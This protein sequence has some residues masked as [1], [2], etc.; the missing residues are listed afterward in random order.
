MMMMFRY[1]VVV[2][3]ERG[4]RPNI[5]AQ[6]D[7]LS[8]TVSFLHSAV[9]FL[10]VKLMKIHFICITVSQLLPESWP[11]RCHT[12]LMTTALNQQDVM[13]KAVTCT[14]VF[15]HKVLIV[16]PSSRSQLSIGTRVCAYWS[17][18]FTCL[19]P[20]TICQPSSDDEDEEEEEEEEERL[21]S[22]DFDDG[23]AGKI[24][25]DYIRMLPT[26]FPLQRTLIYYCLV[27]RCTSGCVVEC[28]ICNRQVAGSNLSLGYFTPRST[29]P[30]MPPG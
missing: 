2:D 20:G 4:N 17:E 18:K 21:F 7:L 27:L 10:I 25:L 14:C 6:E 12:V 22:V 8:H 13:L 1:G 28:R 9:F 23:D 16:R 5:L 24:P 15:L 3:G 19:H 11:C 30:S 29:Q 26:D